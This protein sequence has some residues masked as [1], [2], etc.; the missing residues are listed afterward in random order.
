MIA[1]TVI[2]LHAEA[3]AQLAH[4]LSAFLN[5]GCNTV[6]LPEDGVMRPSDDLLTKAED[7]LSADVVI[8][9]LSDASVPERW[10]RDRWESVLVEQA[11]S[12]RT[13]IVTVLVR[14]CGFPQLL[15]RERF[16]DLTQGQTKGLRLLK[17][18]FWRPNTNESVSVSCSPDLE[19]LYTGLADRTGSLEA[20]ASI[21]VR[22]AEE[23]RQEFE[24]VVWIPCHGRSLAQAAGAAGH[25]LGLALESRAAANAAR[26]REL[27]AERRCLLVLD[28]PNPDVRDSLIP[29]GR[30]STLITCQ[31]VQPV[32][33]TDSVRSARDLFASRR[34]AEAYEMFYRLLRSGTAVEEC[35]RK[36]AWI[37]DLWDR[38]AEAEELRWLFRPAAPV[39]LAL[40]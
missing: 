40:F 39:Q 25:Q 29:G 37:C 6:C 5:L 15:R 17:R 3:D 10:L 24:Q 30:T 35:A 13:G 16:F 1:T 8:L 4:D 31:P 28:S 26:V 20:D 38:P 32:Q 14:E 12:M 9:L 33:D 22:F 34:F 19:H 11:R 23:A 7:A 18:W 27:L 36:L 21:A 2:P